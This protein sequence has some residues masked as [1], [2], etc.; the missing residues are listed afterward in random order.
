MYILGTHACID[1]RYINKVKEKISRKINT[2]LIMVIIFGEGTDSGDHPWGSHPW[3]IGEKRKW[4]RKVF[5]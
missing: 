3:L 1:D 2:K 5:I 4:F